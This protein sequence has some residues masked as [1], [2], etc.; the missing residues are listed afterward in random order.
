MSEAKIKLIDD[1]IYLKE[2]RFADPKELFKFIGNMIAGE[3][4]KETESILDVGCATG[5]FL[6]YL[7]NRFPSMSLSGFDFS[8]N[9]IERARS[10]NSKVEFW[11]GSIL[12]KQAF[13]SANYDLITSIGVICFFNEINVVTALDNLISSL[14]EGGSV[15]IHSTFNP[16]PIDVIMKYRRV[17]EDEADDWEGGWNIFSRKTIES[18]LNSFDYQLEWSWHTWEMPFAIDKRDDPMRAWTIKTENNPFQRINGANQLIHT[19]ILHVR[20]VKIGA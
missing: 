17:N 9:M 18:A 15:F 5:E 19:E 10:R 7:G 3:K 2:D 14:R 8:E 12:D 13:K 4:K 11:S 6:Y 16:N 20:V 1:Q